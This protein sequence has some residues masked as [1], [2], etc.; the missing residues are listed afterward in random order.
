MGTIAKAITSTKLTQ[1]KTLN[2]WAS[3]FHSLILHKIHSTKATNRTNNLFI[4]N[5]S[6]SF[7]QFT[8]P[9]PVTALP[10][11]SLPLNANGTTAAYNQNPKIQ[12]KPTWQ[13]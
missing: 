6:Y 7:K 4:K 9:E 13:M 10:H 11:I 3:Q 8:F 1:I 2:S 12:Q 5:V